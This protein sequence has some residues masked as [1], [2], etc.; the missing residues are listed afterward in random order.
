MNFFG[1]NLEPVAI[2]CAGKQPRGAVPLQTIVILD[3]NRLAFRKIGNRVIPVN[4]LVYSE[5]IHDPTG[6]RR[7]DG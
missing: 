2:G 3:P 4:G 7:R 5:D 6:H 1:D